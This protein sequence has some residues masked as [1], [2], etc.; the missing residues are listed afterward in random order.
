M[1]STHG[2]LVLEAL[3]FTSGVLVGRTS[4]SARVPQPS[5]GV[6]LTV[7]GALLMLVAYVLMHQ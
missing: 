4:L 7:A 1:T 2:W 6:V 3:A 5:T